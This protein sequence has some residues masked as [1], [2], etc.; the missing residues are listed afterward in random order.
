[1]FMCDLGKT[2]YSAKTCI[3]KTLPGEEFD[4]VALGAWGTFCQE[5]GHR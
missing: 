5:G 4:T 2:Q 1:M 3:L